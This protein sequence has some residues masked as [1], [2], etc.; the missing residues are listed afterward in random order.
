[1]FRLVYQCK[2]NNDFCFVCIVKSR[3]HSIHFER[4]TGP[5]SLLEIT[6]WIWATYDLYLIYR[7]LGSMMHISSSITLQNLNYLLSSSIKSIASLNYKQY[8]P[9]DSGQFVYIRLKIGLTQWM[10]VLS[11]NESIHRLI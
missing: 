9:A 3:V 5:K 4:M 2:Q 6:Y 8:H 7:Y 10:Q 1:M 11:Y